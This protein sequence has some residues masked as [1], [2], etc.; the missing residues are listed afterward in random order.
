MRRRKRGP[1]YHP[2]IADNGA[3]TQRA[4]RGRKER[5][6]RVVANQL[7]TEHEA[8]KG[9]PSPKNGSVLVPCFSKKEERLGRL[10][11]HF[12]GGLRGSLFIS[13]DPGACGGILGVSGY[14]AIL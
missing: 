2:I 14:E 4:A 3:R 12:F 13:T 1:E 8:P 6:R 5:N 10:F 7:S 9:A 11:A